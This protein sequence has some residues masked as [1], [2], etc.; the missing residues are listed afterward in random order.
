MEKNVVVDVLYNQYKKTL[1]EKKNKRLEIEPSFI[2]GKITDC[3]TDKCS[4]SDF[5]ESVYGFAVYVEDSDKKEMFNQL[6]QSN[7][8]KSK[9]KKTKSII[10]SNSEEW[11]PLGKS[12]YYPLYWGQGK[13]LLY[14]IFSHTKANVGVGSIWLH[15][16]KALKGKSVIFGT[17]LCYHPHDVEKSLQSSYKQV[18]ITH[19]EP[20]NPN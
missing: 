10:A 19:S 11:L 2:S 1:D 14:R 5:P 3:G 4:I 20:K 9:N 8:D 17:I 12:K 7:Q 16:N 6:I 13:Y 15:R 18:L